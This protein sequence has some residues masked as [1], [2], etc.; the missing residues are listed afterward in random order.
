[1]VK[2]YEFDKVQMEQIL[3]RSYFEDQCWN[4]IRNHLTCSIP[5]I[6]LKALNYIVMDNLNRTYDPPIQI[7]LLSKNLKAA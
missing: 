3:F 4:F 5:S 1:M 6:Q 2:F 7:I